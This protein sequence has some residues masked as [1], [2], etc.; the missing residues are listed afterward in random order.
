MS[1]NI[2][3]DMDSG[4]NASV[5]LAGNRTLDLSNMEAGDTGTIIITQDATGSRTITFGTVNGGGGTHKVV[6]GGGGAIT[7]TA[8][9]SATDI[10]SFMY[11]G[12][13]VWWTVGYNFT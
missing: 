13:T 7:L 11:D 6:N 1:S 2:A 9:A 8:T 12:T 10:L 3:W 4:T 5:T